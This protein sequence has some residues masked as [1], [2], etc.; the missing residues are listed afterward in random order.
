MSRLLEGFF[1]KVS[2]PFYMY[3]CTCRTLT[4]TCPYNFPFF[5]RSNRVIII[6]LMSCASCCKPW[7]TSLRSVTR[8]F[9]LTAMSRR[10][11]TG[12]L[13][14]CLDWLCVSW[15]VVCV[16]F[17]CMCLVW[18]Y[19]PWCRMECAASPGAWWADKRAESDQLKERGSLHHCSYRQRAICK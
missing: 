7:L 14:M 17:G 6:Q 10:G 1:I 12:V 8:L 16:L 15:L 9:L 4:C 13:V 3:T 19:V 5:M 18:L 11:R 2:F